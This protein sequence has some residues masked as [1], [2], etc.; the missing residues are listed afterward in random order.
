MPTEIRAEHVGSLLR[1]SELLA[2]HLDH[3]AGRVTDELLREFEDKAALDA[4]ALQRDAGL[5]IFTDGEVRRE[6]L[7][8]GRRDRRGPGADRHSV[9]VPPEVAP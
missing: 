9:G 4:I 7:G 5:E 8:L 2:A 6:L 3:E 1:P